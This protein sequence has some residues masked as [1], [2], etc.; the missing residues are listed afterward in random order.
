MDNPL[1]LTFDVGTYRTRA[2]LVDSKGTVEDS[3][4]KIYELAYYEIR[5]G[6]AEQ[7]PEVYWDAICET[8]RNLKATAENKWGRI[9]AVT[10]ASIRG[11]T[12]CLDKEGELLRDA[13]IWYDKRET[14]YLP[15]VA[16]KSEFICKM[17]GLG[18]AFELVRRRMDCNWIAIN[19]PEIWEK[20][21]KFVLLSAWINRRFC[22]KLVD[23][24]ASAMGALPYD[25]RTGRWLSRN[26]FRRSVYL[27]SDL[28]LCDLAEPGDVVGKISPK[29]AEETGA[30]L[31]TPYIVAGS[32]L[33]CEAAGLSCV[34]EGDALLALDTTASVAAATSRYFTTL[35]IIP[36]YAGLTGGFLP[37]LETFRGYWLISWYKKQFAEM[38]AREAAYKNCTVENLLNERIRE[39]PPGCD[40]LIVQPTF[41]WDTAK[42][43]ARGT[44]IGFNDTHTRLHIYRAIM[45][46]VHFS[47]M[48]GLALM[49]KKGKIRTRRLYVTGDASNSDVI[50]GMAA[51]MF[52]LPVC[53]GETPFS[54]GIGSAAAA[55]IG[56]GVYRDFKEAIGAMASQP[57]VFKPD[58]STHSLYQRIYKEIYSQIFPGMAPLYEKL[59]DIL[60]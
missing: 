3:A 10:S 9:A 15:P 6:W 17:M 26:D 55:F 22:G 54:S 58:P 49:E 32:D 60:R 7:N 53:R 2:M 1:I 20:T 30:P 40:G 36:P 45:E 44:I 56:L 28:Q 18:E 13:I 52:G 5:P 31:N 59:R 57:E 27:I 43:D 48:E 16:G 14:N 29:A 23:S 19:Q 35:P 38:D 42:P 39:I 50:C 37:E 24:T 46:G 12:L 47:L 11:T 8:A 4:E 21:D 41:V 25:V 51:D 34:G 33:A